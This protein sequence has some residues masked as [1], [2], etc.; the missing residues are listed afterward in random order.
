MKK[1]PYI[2]DE[3]GEDELF[4]I[5]SDIDMRRVEAQKIKCRIVKNAEKADGHGYTCHFATC[6]HIVKNSEE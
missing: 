5:E 2:L 3:A 1:V 4:V 6:E